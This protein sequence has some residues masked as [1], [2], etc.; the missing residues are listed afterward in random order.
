MRSRK[1]LIAGAIIAGAIMGWVLLGPGG[2]ETGDG[3]AESSRRSSRGSSSGSDRAPD[4]DEGDEA[5]APDPRVRAR[6]PEVRELARVLRERIE[7][8]RT[9]RE[10]NEAEG[11]PE[12]VRSPVETGGSAI[13]GDDGAPGRMDPE[14]IRAAVRELRPLLA[15]CYDLAR[16]EDD[17][18]AG[19]LILE[20]DIE[21]E[22]EVG[23]VV[24]HATIGEDST[25]T[26]PILDEC[27]RETIYT[28]ELPA[29]TGGGRVHVRYPFNFS[30][31]ET[32]P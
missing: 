19:R 15:E 10:A 8:A 28:L 18:L 3:E 21:G 31:G 2:Q 11:S 24:E 25:L 17:A 27:I 4:S 7:T 12:E 1:G 22:P 30:S 26:H 9:E 14:Y 5:A 29:P 20:F 6:D 32:A 13:N 23:G 16:E